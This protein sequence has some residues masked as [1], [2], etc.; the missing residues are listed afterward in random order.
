MDMI[1]SMKET[2][3]DMVLAYCPYCPLTPKKGSYP[4]TT[5]K[6]GEVVEINKSPVLKR[7]LR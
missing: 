3:L 4:V 7:V 6:T 1:G 2:F 5:V